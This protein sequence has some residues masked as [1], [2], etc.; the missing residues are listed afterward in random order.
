MSNRN[1]GAIE[2]DKRISKCN[3]GSRLNYNIE[4]AILEKHLIFD[5]SMLLGD[6]SIYNLIDL[7]SCYNRQL[8]NFTSIIKESIDIQREPI[9]LFII[10]LLV[11]KHFIYTRYS[12]SFKFYGDQEDPVGETGQGIKLLGDLC[13]NKSCLIVKIPKSKQLGVIIEALILKFTL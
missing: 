10:V 8:P 7:Q 6:S 2:R 5:N 1:Q 11:F 13:H 4:I 9:K 3:Y 12:L